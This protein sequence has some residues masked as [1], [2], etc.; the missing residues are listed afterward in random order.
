MNPNSSFS[1]LLS[2]FDVLS[3]K[4]LLVGGYALMNYTEPRYTKDL[5]IWVVSSPENAE[6]VFAAL[7]RF[8]AP[9]QG[10][11]K[12]DFSTPGMVYQMGRPPVRVDVL[13]SLTALE[14][15]DCWERRVA[16]RFGEQAVGFISMEDLIVN[17]RAVGRLQDLADVERLEAARK[18]RGA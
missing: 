10:I 1:E 4:Y 11:T 18:Q 12:G 9:L 7:L 15:S 6:N 2:L 3:V 13:T 16:G 8:G 17:K 14:F 5:D